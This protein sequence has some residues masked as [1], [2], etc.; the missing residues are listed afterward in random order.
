MFTIYDDDAY[1]IIEKYK[2]DIRQ[3]I[4][5]NDG[6][7]DAETIQA[8]AREWIAADY[9][10]LCDDVNNFDETTPAQKIYVVASLGLWYG[11]RN[12]S[13]VFT[14]LYAA[15]HRCFED[16]NTL[17]FKDKRSTLTLKAYHHDGLNLFKFYKIIK[18]KKYAIKYADIIRG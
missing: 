17:Y 16:Y 11:R 8:E 4:K 13:A 10:S 6:I 5:D 14:S 3:A 9:Q 1:K 15:L 18:G 12:A 7:P 2:A